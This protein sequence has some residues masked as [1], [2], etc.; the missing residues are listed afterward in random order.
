[1][2][3]LFGDIMD[4]VKI[5]T[6]CVVLAFGIVMVSMSLND[7]IKTSILVLQNGT[8]INCTQFYY[9]AFGSSIVTCNGIKY[10][11]SEWKQVR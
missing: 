11:P 7:S 5:A 9:G 6:L 4:L 10:S 8:E 1:M 2:S 3:I